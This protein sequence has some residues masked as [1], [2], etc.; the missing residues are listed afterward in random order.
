[1]LPGKAIAIPE[2]FSILKRRAWLIVVPPAVTGFA[3]LLYSSTVPNLYQS[4]MLIAIDAQRVPDTFVRSTVT[5]PIDQRLDS[6]TVQVLSRTALQE[7]VERFGLYI[8][9]RA[10]K[11]IEDVVAKM[12]R[13]IEVSLDRPIQQRGM[14]PTPGAFHIRFVHTDPRVAAQVTQHIGSL[15]VE[16]NT[17]DRGRQAGATNRFLE[18]QLSESRAKLE[19]QEA[20]LEKFRQEHGKSQPSQMQ[21]N[22]QA[23]QSAQFSLQSIVESIARD[24]DRKL[25]LERLYR[26]AA[27]E[28]APTPLPVAVAAGQPAADP[29]SAAAASPEDQ[30]AVARAQLDAL[31]LRY[32]PDHPDV[33]RARKLVADLEPKADAQAMQRAARPASTSTEEPPRVVDPARRESLRQMTAEMDSLE[34]QI[35]FKESEERRIRGE[36]TEYQQRLEAVPGLESEWIRLTRDYDTQQAAYRELLTKST[37]AQVAA[38]LEEEEIGERFR[39]V[40]PAAVPVHPLPSL[41]VRFNAAGLGLGLFLGLGLAALLEFRDQSFHSES[42]VLEVLSMPVLAT[43]PKIRSEA[44]KSRARRRMIGLSVAGVA[45]LVVAGYVTWTLKL[46]KSVI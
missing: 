19:E 28:P 29:L 42:D 34:R 46:W 24:R 4:D 21:S 27:N 17:R 20:R 2:V 14:P 31:L 12:R 5:T 35:A 40:D 39:V 36:L 32:K 10:A 22:M 41:R 8:D 3:A 18:E 33:A 23:L 45:Y 6:I 44:E 38:N 11:P 43:V 13:D 7:M 37:A 26:E 15:F 30:L 16:Q 1:M 9:E 25:M